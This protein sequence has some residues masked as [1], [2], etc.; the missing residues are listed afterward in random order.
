MAESNQQA[1]FPAG[2]ET[3]FQDQ[4]DF[5][6]NLTKMG[7][8][9]ERLM[10]A[11]KREQR[12]IQTGVDIKSGT[13]EQCTDDISKV[14][15]SRLT[16]T[17]AHAQWEE[18][19]GSKVE[20]RVAVAIAEIEYA[21]LHLITDLQVRLGELSPTVNTATTLQGDIRTDGATGR[22]EEEHPTYGAGLTASKPAQSVTK[23]SSRGSRRSRRTSSTTAMKLKLKTEEAALA[24]NERFD[25]ELSE[26]SMRAINRDAARAAEDAAIA[27]EDAK[28]A[29]EDRLR[30]QE[31]AEEDRLRQQERAE[32]DRLRQ[33]ERVDREIRRRR[34][35]LEEEKLERA[36]AIKRQKEI[37]RAKIEVVD[38]YEG[39]SIR[40]GSSVLEEVEITPEEKAAVFVNSSPFCAQSSKPQLET[41]TDNLL[42]A[43][44]AT[45]ETVKP[46]R[47]PVEHSLNLNYKTQ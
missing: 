25:R 43:P 12:E 5:Q 30:Q 8:D 31:K 21:A 10:E 13:A 44:M 20:D 19:S 27:A 46:N 36:E 33:Q 45:N 35:E 18:A 26:R 40:T 3:P 11:I 17:N 9:L 38:S 42:N 41:I 22:T 28:R 4:E 39:S 34:E 32:V 7:M 2:L 47:A 14:F 24:V 6:Q 37:I 1:N 23:Q 15:A 16:L 29:E